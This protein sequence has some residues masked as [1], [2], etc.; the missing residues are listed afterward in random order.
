[1]KKAK[2]FGLR[3]DVYEPI[4]LS[5]DKFEVAVRLQFGIIFNNSDFYSRSLRHK[6][7]Q[8][9]LVIYDFG[10]MIVWAFEVLL[11]YNDMDH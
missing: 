2:I 4:S 11:W 10:K 6:N 1:M 8:T 3:W 7:T 5:L 9:C